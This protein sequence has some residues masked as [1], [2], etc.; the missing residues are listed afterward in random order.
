MNTS[1]AWSTQATPLSSVAG[2]VMFTLGTFSIVI[3]A[4]TL[5]SGGAAWNLPAYACLALAACLVLV[6]LYRERHRSALLLSWNPAEGGF[7]VAGL[8]GNPVLTRVWS[9]PGWV[10]LGLS[11]Q[12][13]SNRAVRLV[14]W[15]S[16]IPAPLWSEL[17]LRI[18]AAQL[19]GNGHQNKEN[20]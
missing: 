3:A 14:V 16:A 7:C 11:H 19:H 13:P 17:A 12:A 8:S 15:K 5:A 4:L 18:E 20:P 9:G 10:T 2:A 6:R 1:A